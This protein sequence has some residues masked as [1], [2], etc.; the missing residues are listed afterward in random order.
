M[1]Y[2]TLL[3]QAVFNL[4]RQNNINSNDEVQTYQAGRYVSSNEAVWR[5]LGF[6]LHERHPAVQHLAVHLENGQ[7]VY[8]NE[9]NFHDRLLNPPLTTLTAFFTLCQQDDFAK[10]LLYVEIPHYF[11][12]V[13]ADK[14]WQR[15]KKGSPVENWP[16]IYFTETLGRV[17]TIHINNMESFCL[18][19]L[20]HTITGPTSFL[21]LK[22]VHNIQYNTFKDTRDALGLLEN[23]N[24]W[25]TTLQEAELCQA[26]HK[27]RELFSILLTSCG[28]TNPLQLWNTFKESMS[29]D[30]LYQFQ[31]ENPSITFN[32]NIFNY[33]L[34]RIDDQVMSI[35]GKHVKDFGLP[36]PQT[37][38]SNNTELL[39]ES[40]Y[41]IDDLNNLILQC[42]PQLLP[43]QLTFFNMIMTKVANNEPGLIFLDAPGGTGKT[44]LLNLI[45]AQLRSTSNIAIDIA[46]SGIAATLLNGGRTAHS[47]LQLLINLAAAE[48]PTCNITQNSHRGQLL[49]KCKLIVWDECTMSH[50]NG[51]EALDRT[52]KDLRHNNTIMGGMVVILAGDFRQ[53]LPVIAKGTPAN[54]LNACIKSSYLWTHITKYKLT[55]NMR[56]ALH[57]DATAAQFSTQLLEIGEGKLP[58]DLDGNITFHSNF[59]HI[60]DSTEELIDKVFFNIINNYTS[61]EWL[62]ERAILAPTNDIANKINNIIL[63]SIPGETTTL[64]SVD[65]IINDDDTILYTPDFLNSLEISGIPSHEL[66]LK[67]GVPVILMRNLHAPRLCN[68]TRLRVTAI[69]CNVIQAKILSGSSK[70]D[71]VLIPR[72]PIIPSDLPF[73]FKRLQFP[74]K[75]AFCMT[76]NKAQGQ[77]LKVSGLHLQTTCFSHG[78]LYVAC[79]RVSNPDK[80]YALCDGGKTSNIVYTNAL[81]E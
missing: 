21:Y 49:Q 63:Q 6:P 32:D 72:I 24:H 43:E 13:N 3:N 74:L 60:V 47:A 29:T 7:R 27:L 51:L 78:Q 62:F 50:K 64:R 48:T 70:G 16:G 44:Y 30:F 20:L 23:E 38:L 45:L 1:R 5:I 67:I 68:G 73:Q 76:I 19:L 79:S 65:T 58:L 71:E 39:R 55:T 66:C 4:A 2:A 56:V 80:L 81:T 8:F 18:R 40:N 26:P 59:C 14:K 22:T 11:K 12:W 37:T 25:H 77:T 15:R 52:L 35:S 9:N 10:Q 33:T 69:S 28:L 41:N 31:Q 57:N 34:S 75:I 53:T 46:S 42:L 54:Q 36:Q 61:D 17:Y